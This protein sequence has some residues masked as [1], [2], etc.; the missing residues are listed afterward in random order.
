M[1]V[2]NSLD[3]YIWLRYDCTKYLSPLFRD[4]FCSFLV[5]PCCISKENYGHVRKISLEN[6]QLDAHLIY[7][8]IRLLYSSPCFQHYMFI[9]RRLNCID[10]ASGIFISV[11][12]RLV[13]RLR[14]FSLNLCTGRPLTERKIPDA[15]SIH[16]SLLLMSM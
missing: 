7:F 13:H 2:V 14:D 4:E 16:F 11:S 15:A 1:Y 8:T 5:M 10:A 12:G 9:I 6:D 3:S